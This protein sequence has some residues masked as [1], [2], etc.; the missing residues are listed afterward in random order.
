MTTF[1][2]GGIVAAIVLIVFGAGAI[3]TGLVGR[4]DVA[5]KIAQ[6]KISGSPDMNPADT[7]TAVEEAG[8]DVAIPD[9]DV[10]EQEIASGTDAK[11]FAE[12]LRVHTLEATGG[13]TYAEM[14]R[15][16]TDDGAGTNDADAA[17]K[18]E[19]GSPA[20]N[21]ARQIWITSTALSTA[22]NTSFF[23]QQVALFAIVMGIAL[24]LTGIGFL[25]LVLGLNRREPA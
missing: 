21:P 5:D 15:F 20:D 16:A 25:V 10:A 7:R 3:V 11:C 24:V 17:A 18:R 13:K 12:Y 6:E 4:A 14:P 1:R 19:D 23:A 8:L 9:C 2:N 22:M